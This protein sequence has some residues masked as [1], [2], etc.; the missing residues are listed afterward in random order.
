MMEAMAR[1]SSFT[2]DFSL[3]HPLDGMEVVSLFD[4]VRNNM[5]V[6]PDARNGG[7]PLAVVGDFCITIPGHGSY[8]RPT[9][10]FFAHTLDRLDVSEMAARYRIKDTGIN[11]VVMVRSHGVRVEFYYA[12]DREFA[13]KAPLIAAADQRAALERTF[14]TFKGVLR[15]LPGL[16]SV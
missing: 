9:T 12:V 16:T 8:F 14:H 2:A 11:A 15:D 7:T 6:I 3:E 13:L 1:N 10:D 4:M 5:P